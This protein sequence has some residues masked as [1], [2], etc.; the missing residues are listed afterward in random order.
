MH[1]HTHIE[2]ETK[3]YDK[4]EEVLQLVRYVGDQPIRQSKLKKTRIMFR[5]MS[6]NGKERQKLKELRD[7][8]RKMNK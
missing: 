6:L 2:D 5:R 4:V 1:A 3:F 7:K 8:V